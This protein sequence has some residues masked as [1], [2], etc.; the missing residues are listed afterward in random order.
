GREGDCQMSIKIGGPIPRWLILT[1]T[2]LGGVAMIIAPHAFLPDW[3]ILTEIFD[4]IGI[5]FLT[6]S[7]LAVTIEKWL[8]SDLAKDIFLAAIGY[9][10]PSNYREA[11]KREL[12]RLASYTF[13]CEKHILLITIEPKGDTWVRVTAQIERTMRNIT[14]SSQ[15]IH[16]FIHIDEWGHPEE[17]SR[18]EECNIVKVN[19]GTKLKFAKIVTHENLSI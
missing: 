9:H 16:A 5:A 2:G 12:N 19:G 8:R 10:L 1:A 11:L 18:I 14:Q 13:L 17:K 4:G 3:C 7:I 6:S 15:D